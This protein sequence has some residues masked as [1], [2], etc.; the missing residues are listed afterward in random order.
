MLVRDLRYTAR[1]RAEAALGGHRPH[2]R[3]V[4]R[5]AVIRHFPRVGRDRSVSRWA[6]REERRARQ[7]LRADAR[8]L[9]RLTDGGRGARLD[10]RGAEE[11]EIR[12]ARH[13]RAALWLA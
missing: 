1:C 4:R 3:A 9:L 2:P 12:P 8:T 6:A 7:R 13:R 10:L 5:R 11:A